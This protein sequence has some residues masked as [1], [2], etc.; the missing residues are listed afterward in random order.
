MKQINS[1]YLTVG[2][3]KL[4]AN[5]QSQHDPHEA[6]NFYCVFSPNEANAGI[7]WTCSISVM[8]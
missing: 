5:M 4:E 8:D 6:N 2:L 3:I 7:C 1:S